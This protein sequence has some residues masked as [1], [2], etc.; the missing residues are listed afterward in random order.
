[1]NSRERVMAALHLKE[2]DRVPFMDFVDTAV[3]HEIMGTEKIDEVELAKKI[4]MDA[5]YFVDYATPLFCK[6]HYGNEDEAKAYGL[7]GETEFIG[8]GLI[9][10]EKDLDKIVLPDPCD[11]S[12]YDPAKRFM[13]RYHDSD[14]AIYAGLRPFGM[15]NTIYSMPMMD[16]AVALRDNLQLINTMMDIFIDWNLVILEKLQRLGIDFIVTYNDMAYK[17]GPLVSPQTFR[18]VFLP[19]MKIVADAIKLPWAFHSD[20]NLT[21]VMEDLLTL[22][23]NCVNPFEPPVMD[24]KVAKA[25]WGDRIC[26]WGNI[27]LVQTLPYGTTADVEAEVKQR[28]KDAGVGG[29]Y[30]CASANSIT[31]FCKIENIFAMTNAVKKHGTYPLDLD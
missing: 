3:K 27:D 29:G 7:T 20:G 16:F 4:G 12:F 14:L 30:I 6:S 26:L 1:M 10:S 9:C 17:E 5:I 13:E 19:K 23:M 22:G 11:E 24:L 8:E 28:I 2:P 25:K 15:F 31:D 21:I 18:E